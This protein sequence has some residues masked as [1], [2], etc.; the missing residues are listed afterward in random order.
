M[1]HLKRL[2]ESVDYGN[3][4]PAQELLLMEEGLKYD[5]VSVFAGENFLFA[6]T[7]TGRVIRL[8]LTNFKGKIKSAYWMDPVTG[9]QTFIC[10]V[11]GK[12]EAVFLPPERED[13]SDSVLVI[14]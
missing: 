11:T 2:M 12:E 9:M 4:R 3:G 13:G 6:Y 5:Y 8:S 10:E 7:C 14:R 1:I